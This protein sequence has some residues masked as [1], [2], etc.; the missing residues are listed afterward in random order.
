M[1]HIDNLKLLRQALLDN[2]ALV[3][4]R[5]K[6]EEWCRTQGGYTPAPEAAPAYKHLCGT[7]MCGLGWAAAL[8]IGS[9][10]PD[11]DRF[12]SWEAYSK[13]FVPSGRVDGCRTHWDFL[14]GFL[15]S[16]EFT[17]LI[18]RIDYAIEFNAPP[19]GWDYNWGTASTVLKD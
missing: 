9:T 11:K 18:K 4:G 8:G 16:D 13:N 15:W 19:V 14:F 1:Y 10:N 5:I 3:E 6:M 17:H 12:V 7:C 2:R